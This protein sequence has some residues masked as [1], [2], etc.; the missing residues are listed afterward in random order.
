M[1]TVGAHNKHCC[2]MQS[3]WNYEKA[4]VDHNKIE[5]S[6]SL[7]QR[8]KLEVERSFLNKVQFSPKILVHPGLI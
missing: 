2:L 5:T 1:D 8:H 6:L 3:L 7:T 4:G